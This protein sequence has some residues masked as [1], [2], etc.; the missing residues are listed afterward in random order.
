MERQISIFDFPSQLHRGWRWLPWALLLAITVALYGTSVHFN[1]VW[2]DWY[3]VRDNPLISEWSWDGLKLIWTSTHLGHYAPVM[4]TT[5][6]WLRHLFGLEPFGFHLAQLIV[7]SSCVVLVYLLLRKV[8]SGRVA[9]LAALL[10][11]VHPANIE[12]IAWVSELKSTLAFLFFLLSFWFFIRFRE[13]ERWPDAALAAIFLAISLLAKI[14]TVVAPAIFL[15]Y[16]YRQG[17]ELKT[18]RWK[19]LLAFFL[20]S[21]AMTVIHLRAFHGNSQALQADYYEGLATHIFG[22]PSVLAF[23]LQMIVLPYP[24]A[25]W[26]MFPAPNEHLLVNI[27]GWF[28]VVA[29]GWLLYRSN[30]NVQFWALWI[31]VFL[32]PVLQLVPFGIWV[33]DR[34]L[35]I[36]AI[37]G[38]VLIAQAFF[39]FLE[40]H[41]SRRKKIV[42]NAAMSCAMLVLAWQTALHL[43]AWKHD[44]TLWAA[45]LPHCMSSA[46]CHASY[47]LALQGVG[48]YQQG[49]EE[50]ALAVRIDPQS[51]VFLVYLADA[52]SMNA[53]NYPAA[54]DVY[55]R[56]ILVAKEEEVRGKR[57]R[58][59]LSSIYSRLTRTYIIAG[60]FEFAGMAIQKGKQA[61]PSDPAHPAMQALLEWKLGNLP[62]ARRAIESLRNLTGD[63]QSSIFQLIGRHW[64]DRALVFGFLRDLSS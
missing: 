10:F 29:M 36:P 61:D 33:A 2:D 50:L 7:H 19:S 49:G 32:A 64:G 52:L 27:L 54:I 31:L 42:A 24:I 35:Y 20:I 12:S 15:L 21:G 22:I 30:R 43:P 41:E 4:I 51:R 25:A 39:W 56:A 14:N 8:E 48:E 18:L 46:Y 17:A 23:Y 63:H 40:R 62:A 9:L 28:G 57:G 47:G 53:R 60:K 34:Y 38:F 45:T 11:V 6:A 26:Q 44:V 13:Q 3:Y 58:I 1:F 55:N 16:D 37:G 59:A 5:L